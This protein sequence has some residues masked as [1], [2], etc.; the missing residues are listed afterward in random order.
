MKMSIA[1][2]GLL[3]A[4]T[5]LSAIPGNDTR[6]VR[7]VPNGGFSA[8]AQAQRPESCHCTFATTGGVEC[9]PIVQCLP[10]GRCG[11]VC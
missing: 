8:W 2:L 7:S 6:S 1:A 5:A 3:A 11:N 9:L 4:L 10:V